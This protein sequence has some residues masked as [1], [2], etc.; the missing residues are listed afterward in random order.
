MGLTSDVV[1][2]LIVDSEVDLTPFG[3]WLTF[4]PGSVTQDPL[5]CHKL[6]YLGRVQ[7]SLPAVPF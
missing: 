7:Q 4:Q 3:T 2:L 5:A 1:V 6:F